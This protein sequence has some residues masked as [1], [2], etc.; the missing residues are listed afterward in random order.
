MPDKGQVLAVFNVNI[1]AK[2]S[3]EICKSY[4]KG[5]IT[6][7]TNIFNLKFDFNEDI[8]PRFWATAK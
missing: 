2:L 5:N 7:H 4:I 8:L 3:Y 6:P 1:L